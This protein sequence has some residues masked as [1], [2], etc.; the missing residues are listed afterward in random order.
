MQEHWKTIRQAPRYKIS[1][2]GNVYSKINNIP[3]KSYPDKKGYIRVQLYLV[4]DKAITQKVH[5]LA[6]EHFI[7]NP[8]KLPQVNHKNGNKTDNRVA[9]L[10]WCN[11]KQNMAHAVE[12]GL[13]NKRQDVMEL[14]PQI[15]TALAMGYRIGDIAENLNT[16][17]KTINKMIAKNNAELEP[18]TS[19][20]VGNRKKYYYFD[21][22]RNRWRV[23]AKVLGIKSKQF[24]TEEEAKEYLYNN[25]KV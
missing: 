18:I 13:F 19:L 23:E 12:N 20:V 25:H 7:P 6:A 21:K 3:K 14:I 10:E 17:S 11:N 2:L 8:D 1:N 16:S 5:R 22:T 24:K 15:K 4:A 9:N